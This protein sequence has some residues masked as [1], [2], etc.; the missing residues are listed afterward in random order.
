MENLTIRQIIEQDI[1]AL[2]KIRTK[3]GI[4]ECLLSLPSEPIETTRA[5]FLD[6]PDRKHTFIA[7]LEVDGVNHTV[8]YICL[9]LDRNIRK[10]H[11]GQVSIAVAS[12][13]QTRGVAAKLI[14]KALYLGFNWLML[15]KIE[16][17]VLVENERAIRLYKRHGFE[18]EGLF[19]EDTIVN[20]E[21]RDVYYMSIIQRRTE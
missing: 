13:F 5:Y 1:T 12:E 11:K 17:I 19:K 9:R 20:G 14:D 6:E 7:E 10:R 18:I 2:N 8:G 3:P 15:T 21:Y 16:L 4:F